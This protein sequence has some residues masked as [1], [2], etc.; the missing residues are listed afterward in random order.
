MREW[1]LILR[2]LLCGALLLLPGGAGCVITIDPND[3][4]GG[5]GG[6]GAPPGPDPVITIRI[7]NATNT[8][9]DPQIFLAAGAVSI[10]ELF[11]PG[12]KVTNFGVGTLGLLGPLGSDTITPTCTSAVV[13]GT[14]GGAFGDDLNNPEG[15]GRQVVLTQDVNVSCG[16]TITFTYERSGSGF[17]TAFRV[18]R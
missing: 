8:T 7:V 1:K 16:D 11:D 14:Q 15:N 2:Y 17:D 10:A 9:L 3:G 6:G 5:G 13:I 4:G 12:R 18:S